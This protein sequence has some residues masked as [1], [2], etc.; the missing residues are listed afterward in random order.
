MISY[1][2]VVPCYPAHFK[3]L[4]SLINQINNFQIDN[5]FTIKEIIICASE[6]DKLTED[7]S[8][9]KY[10]IVF[11]CVPDKCNASKNRNRGLDVASADY[12]IF[13]DADDT[14][15]FQKLKVT[16]EIISNLNKVNCVLHGYHQR[17]VPIKWGYE[18]INSY[19]IVFNDTTKFL[20]N[21]N[22]NSNV[23]PVDI[24]VHHGVSCVKSSIKSRFIEDLNYGEDGRFCQSILYNEGGLICTD[25]KLM[26]YNK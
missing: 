16:S 22:I 25:A 1:S 13:L 11:S 10:P 2:I 7:L 24:A 6:V 21:P 18:S 5:Y 15:H 14:Y 8:H 12:V 17:M 23:V 3:Y 4:S 26:C 19:K 9:T 20:T